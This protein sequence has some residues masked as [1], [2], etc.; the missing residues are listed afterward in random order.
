MTPLR[1][2]MLE[3][4]QVRNLSPHTQRAYVDTVA[5]FARHVGRS[6]ALLEPEEIRAYQV[7]LTQERKLAPSSLVIAA[8]ALRFLYKVTLKRAW[9]WDAVIPAPRKPVIL[10]VVLS[11][12]E[13]VHFLACVTHPAHRTILTTCYA[14]GLR[15]SEAVRL[16]LPAIDSQR[17]VLRVEDGKGHQDRYVM[18]SPK[19]LVILRDW[20]RV[21]RPPHWLF[22]GEH[23]DQPIT[24]H[25]VRE[26]CQRAHRRARI[27]KPITPHS[28]RHYLPFLTMSSDIEH[29]SRRARIIGSQRGRGDRI[30]RHSL[31][32]PTG[33]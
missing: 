16:T 32:D 23:S 14:T 13:V 33:C 12:E 22:P 19:L 10:P 8:C 5:R 11:P 3:D 20:W 31:L 17:M 30:A 29:L 25:A 2:R 26:A 9:A 21:H 7:Y 15:I 1:Q 28:L 18:L 24:S 4:M 6:P 27:P